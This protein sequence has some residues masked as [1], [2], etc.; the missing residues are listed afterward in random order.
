MAAF[1]PF[2][3]SAE[4]WAGG[5]LDFAG[6]GCSQ[7]GEAFLF[8]RRHLTFPVVFKVR[9]SKPP[10]NHIGSDRLRWLV[11]NVTTSLVLSL[12]NVNLPA[13]MSPGLTQPPTGDTPSGCCLIFRPECCS[14]SII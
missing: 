8:L 4:P 2:I 13:R 11:C 3:V 5:S 6:G 9:V 7:A 12:S 1:S 14:Q 10:G